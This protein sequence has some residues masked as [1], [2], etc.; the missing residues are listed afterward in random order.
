[1][2]FLKGLA[3][4]LLSFLLFLSLSIFSSV[5]MLNSTI[6]N[7]DF[8]T[9]EINR[10]DMSSLAGEFLSEQIPQE[11]PY[12]GEVLDKTIT[13][14]EPWIKEQASTAIYSGYDYFLGRTESLNLIIS[15]ETVK[16]TLKENLTEAILSSPPPGLQGTSPAVIRQYAD[17]AY[18]QFANDIPQTIELTES[19]IPPDVMATLKQVR[20]YL[21]YYQTAYYGLIVLM[22]LFAL[23][24]CLVSRDVKHTTRSIGTPLAVYGVIGYAIIFALDYFNVEEQMLAMTD[25]IPWSLLTWMAQFMDNLMAPMKTF[26][27]ALLITGVILIIVS[28]VYRR[29]QAPAEE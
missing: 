11:Q 17:Q 6:L 12:V 5:F 25:G 28:I 19:S 3:L 8:V 26:A 22:V 29:R 18:Q 4:S 23:G 24:I 21:S 14:L 27:L 20:S 13:D 16:S 1:M 10:L 15:T 9:S 2:N 7:P